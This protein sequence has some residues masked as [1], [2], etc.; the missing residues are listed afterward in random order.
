M[1]IIKTLLVPLML[2][3]VHPQ[4]LNQLLFKLLWIAVVNDYDA[5]DKMIDLDWMLILLGSN[6]YRQ[7]N[8]IWNRSLQHLLGPRR[9]GFF[10]NCDNSMV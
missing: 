5:G 10:L 2:G 4:L 8:G 9:G 7:N 3:I 6:G 1:T